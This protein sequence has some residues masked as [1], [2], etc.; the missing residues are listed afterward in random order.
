M[1]LPSSTR[2]I[3]LERHTKETQI[4]LSL[5]LDGQGKC[6]VQTGLGFLDHMITSLAYHARFDLTLLCSGDVHIDSHHTTE[7]CALLLGQAIAQCIGERKGI[8][9]FGSAYAPLDEALSRCVIDL[10]GRPWPDINL[11]L[12]R[13]MIGQVACEDLVHF[14]QSL[15]MTLKASLHVDTLKGINDHHRVESAFKACALALRSALQ[16]TS[17]P[18][19]A[20]STKGGLSSDA[21]RLNQG[22]PLVQNPDENLVFAK[23]QDSIIQQGKDS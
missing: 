6:Q 18:Y 12:K 11:G 2:S 21:D 20:L 22:T 3:Q 10:S 14:F 17:S 7:D 19:E 8:M 13:E 16:Q 15:A 4:N 9:R 5:C 23:K 1:T